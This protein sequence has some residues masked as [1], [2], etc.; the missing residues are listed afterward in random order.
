AL[1]KRAGRGH[2]PRG[3]AGWRP[4]G[5][6]PRRSRYGS[7]WPGPLE[8][9]P[10][11]R[12][13]AA[14]QRHPVRRPPTSEEGKN[15]PKQHPLRQTL[16]SMTDEEYAF[17]R[18]DI[19]RRGLQD[20]ILLLDGQVL[21]GWHRYR[22][23]LELRIQPKFRAVGRGA[24]ALAEVISRNLARRQLSPGQRYGVLLR[25]AERHPQVRASLGARQ[26]EPP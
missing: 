15:L 14:N 10:T 8:K 12:R 3:A 18:A 21:D 4:S 6:R 24:D 25:I 16:P 1:R 23:C 9:R 26:Q 7:G 22:I 13:M 11:G 19:E 20:P 17:V 2:R 5:T